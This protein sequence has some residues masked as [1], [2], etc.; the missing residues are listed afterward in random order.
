[1]HSLCTVKVIVWRPPA[2]LLTA[3][4]PRVRRPP[5]MVTA[6]AEHSFF[7][8]NAAW[9]M[10]EWCCHTGVNDLQTARRPCGDKTMT[11]CAHHGSSPACTSEPAGHTIAGRKKTNVGMLHYPRKAT[12]RTT[13]GRIKTNGGMLHYPR[14]TTGHTTSGRIKTNG[15]M[16][17]YPRKTTWRTASGRIKTNGGM[18]YYP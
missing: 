14:K 12:W 17:H 8:H 15:G 11:T 3:V 18:L 9:N 5:K 10:M 6:A 13:S 16:L 7:L 1:M 4:T 2:A